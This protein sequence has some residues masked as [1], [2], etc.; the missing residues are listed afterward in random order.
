[1]VKYRKRVE[2]LC[3]HV[4]KRMTPV[5]GAKHSEHVFA[6]ACRRLVFNGLSHTILSIYKSDPF[7]HKGNTAC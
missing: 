7:R 3:S 4:P 2:N 5:G 1:M 6:D